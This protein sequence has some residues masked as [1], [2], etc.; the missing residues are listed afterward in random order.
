MFE[1]VFASLKAL[2]WYLWDLVSNFCFYFTNIC[3]AFL[4]I[5]QLTAANVSECLNKKGRNFA[6]FIIWVFELCAVIF[7]DGD[8][9]SFYSPLPS[10]RFF[11]FPSHGCKRLASLIWWD[12]S[13]R[14]F[15]KICLFH[16]RLLEKLKNSFKYWKIFEIFHAMSSMVACIFKQLQMSA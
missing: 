15:W 8:A 13:L 6:A 10:S 14:P 16:R 11:P 9:V 1:R 3:F 2:I 7:I 4:C 5:A 12:V